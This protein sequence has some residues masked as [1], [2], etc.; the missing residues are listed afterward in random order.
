VDTC[1]TAP[2]LLVAIADLKIENVAEA[3]LGVSW[4]GFPPSSFSA[5]PGKARENSD[6]LDTAELISPRIA[7]S[8]HFSTI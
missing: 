5:V 7:Q 8:N 4:L 2:A 3:A 6:Q 1:D